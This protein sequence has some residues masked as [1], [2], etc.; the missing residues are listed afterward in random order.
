MNRSTDK[1]TSKSDRRMALGICVGLVVAVI[2]VFGQVIHFD[3]ISVDDDFYVYRNPIVARGLTWEGI[4]W[5]FTHAHA[6]NWHPL[7]WL[8]HMVDCRLYGLRAGGHHATSVLLHAA[9]AVLL[10]LLLRRMTNTLWPGAFVAALFALHPLRV[11]SVAWVAERKDVLS[12]LFFMLTFWTYVNYVSGARCQVSGGEANAKG[13]MPKAKTLQPCLWYWLTLLCF[14]LG[15]LSK[16]MLVTLPFVLLLLDYWPLKRVSG[17]TYQVSGADALSTNLTPRTSHL[18]LL[19]EKLPLLALAVGSCGLTIWAQRQVG[20]IKTGDEL[21]IP[22]RLANAAVAYVGYVGQLFFPYRLAA[23]YP[24][25]ATGLPL[26][27]IVGAVLVLALVTVAVF[28]GR[29]FGYLPVGWLWYLGMLVPVIGLVQVGAQAHADRYTYLPQIGLALIIAFGLADFSS[30]WSRS[31]KLT[32]AMAG[33]AGLAVL[34]SCS[35]RQTQY[36]RN[37]ET[38]W[39]RALKCNPRSSWIEKVLGDLLSDQGRLDEAMAY[40]RRGAEI[41]PNYAGLR[42]NFGNAL[43]R[44]SRF[45]EARRELEA[46]IQAD[47]KMTDAHISLGVVLFLQE[48]TDL[49]IR[50]FQKAL[51]LNPNHPAALS[52]LGVVLERL[53]RTD[54]AIALYRRAL[55]VNPSFTDAHH[56]LARL[57]LGRGRAAEAIPHYEQALKANPNDVTL[58]GDLAEALARSGQFE[59]AVTELQQALALLGPEQETV[60]QKLR[61]R[62]KDYQAG[63]PGQAKP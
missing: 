9:N 5:A 35:W 36:W 10:F 24:H 22:W 37:S 42:L 6:A 16:P 59:Q 55:S 12:G 3:F 61:D 23:Y 29:R 14:A 8:S 25:P 60:A 32:L 52:D 58:R 54:E 38:L 26:L 20:A 27:E 44:V 13:Q 4:G 15:L 57:L 21:A 2:C 46:A 30:R 11:E 41:S 1:P 48:E 63:Q 19:V 47:P 33:A 50:H 28:R 43:Y 31:A 53:G 40:Y 45:A 39:T 7:T 51:A 56:N 18:T 49:A 62:L 17:V 34:A